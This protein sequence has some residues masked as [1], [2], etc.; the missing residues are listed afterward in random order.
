MRK[1]RQVK[2]FILQYVLP[3]LTLSIFFLVRVYFLDG[4]IYLQAF[5]LLGI[6]IVVHSAIGGLISGLIALTYSTII[7]SYLY[8]EPINNIDISS[9]T[10]LSR[11]ITYVFSSIVISI[12]VSVFSNNRKQLKKA[13]TDLKKTTRRLRRVMDSIFTM[14]AI[15]DRTGKIKEANLSYANS[16]QLQTS[17]LINKN[18]FEIDPWNNNHDLQYSLKQALAS[19]NAENPIKFEHKIIIGGNA[20]FSEIGINVI[21]EDEFEEIVL[22]VRDRTDKKKY[23]DELLKSQEIL[24]RLIDSNVIGMALADL[25]GEFIETNDEFLEFLGLQTRGIHREWIKLGQNNTRRI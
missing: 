18:I 16:L 19:V 6:F 3:I 22:T 4:N 15:L 20:L 24:S 25:K 9:N 13:T 5:S 12:F 1:K 21:K 17:E 14:V 8:L 11:T 10:D 2:K 23:E 7:A